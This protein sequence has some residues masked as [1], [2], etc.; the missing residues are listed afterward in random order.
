MWNYILNSINTINPDLIYI[1]IGCSM[2]SYDHII[3]DNNQ[4]YP[5]FI[6]NFNKKII[7]LIDPCLEYPLAIQ[8]ILNYNNNIKFLFDKKLRYF[9]TNNNYIYA[10]N[11][12]FHFHSE[13]DINY[14]NINNNDNNDNNNHD[15]DILYNIIE[16][17]LESYNLKKLIIQDY[18]GRD[19][20]WYYISLLKYFNKNILSS[21]I[22]DTTQLDGGCFINLDKITILY[23]NL[24]NFIQEKYSKLNI[25]KKYN[26][27]LYEK[28]LAYR[29]NILK[30]PILSYYTNLYL[31][32]D[33]E[34]WC[35]D[36]WSKKF[37]KLMSIIYNI[38]Y[39]IMNT[40]KDYILKNTFDIIDYTLQDI[41]N[42]KNLDI[43][44]YNLLLENLLNRNKFIN[45]I[46]SI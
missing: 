27:T 32:N 21:V 12:K 2:I 16:L 10:I 42:T 33:L 23:D 13:Y 1:A 44:I 20:T 25:I 9:N 38:N 26:S 43:A 18:T 19:L 34:K 4:Q 22:F 30:Y 40:D 36:I 17:V 14:Y 6:N 46:C 24:G 8:K 31:E 5:N 37:I 41:I 28:I 7:I 15:M 45:I 11:S 39:D 29:I 3:S 35:N